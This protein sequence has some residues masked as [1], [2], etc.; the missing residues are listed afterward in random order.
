MAQHAISLLSARDIDSYVKLIDESYEGRSEIVQG[1]IQGPVGVRQQL[2]M[3]F[4]AFPDIHL[5]LEQ[6]IASGD[7]IATRVRLSGTHQGNFAG[8]AP[9]NRT[10]S[11]GACNVIELRN[12]KV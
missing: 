9:T 6:V 5:E 1:P 2:N 8:I 11:W 3:L 4:S 10:V 12:G 7:S